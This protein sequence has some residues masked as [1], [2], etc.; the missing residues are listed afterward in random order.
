LLA[1]YLSECHNIISLPF[2]SNNVK[3]QGW[4]YEGES[5]Y[6]IPRKETMLNYLLY[7]A[8][9]SIYQGDLNQIPNNALQ[10]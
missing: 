3:G 2:S 4:G 10:V 8:E 5:P 1:L 6:N 9:T 7:E